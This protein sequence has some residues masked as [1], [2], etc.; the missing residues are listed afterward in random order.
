MIR[1]SYFTDLSNDDY[2]YLI[3]N[4]KFL[5]LNH[6]EDNRGKWQDNVDVPYR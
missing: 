4:D 6:K 3:F 5:S 1:K 2:T